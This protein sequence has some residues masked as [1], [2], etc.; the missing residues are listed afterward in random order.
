LARPK[1]P[2]LTLSRALL[3]ATGAL[4][5]V[6]EA[7]AGV[8]PSIANEAVVATL[9]PAMHTAVAPADWAISIATTGFQH[10]LD[11][12]EWV[13]M[14]LDAVV[15]IV[16]AHNYCGGDIVLRMSAGDTVTLE[17]NG[18]TGNYVVSEAR[19]AWAGEN[20]ATATS[21]LSA[22]VILQTCYYSNDGRERLV[23][24]IRQAPQGAKFSLHGL[25]IE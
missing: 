25:E 17:G 13:R 3:L 2:I 7:L 23:G 11:S 14:N 15:P 9:P 8:G 4:V 12:C 18:L 1:Q 20:A 24:L 16:G 6:A 21:G 22:T 19:D 5:L 10:E